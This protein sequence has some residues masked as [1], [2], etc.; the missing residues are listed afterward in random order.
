MKIAE[1]GIRQDGAFICPKP[2]PSLANILN[3][4]K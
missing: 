4:N 3:R 1:I 2:Y